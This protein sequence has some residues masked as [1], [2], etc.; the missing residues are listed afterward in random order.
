MLVRW[1]LDSV[2]D[3]IAD[4]VLILICA[5]ISLLTRAFYAAGKFSTSRCLVSQVREVLQY[6]IRITYGIAEEI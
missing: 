4:H 6:T 2:E 3:S 1:G 5:R